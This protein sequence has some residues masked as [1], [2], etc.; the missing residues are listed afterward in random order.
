MDEEHA[1]MDGDPIG[2]IELSLLKEIGVEEGAET[3]VL[4]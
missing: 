1:N 2:P 3:N 4:V